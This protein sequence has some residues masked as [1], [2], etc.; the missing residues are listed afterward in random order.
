MKTSHLAAIV[1]AVL[2]VSA[3]PNVAAQDTRTVLVQKIA[4]A[5]GLTELVDQQLAQQHEATKE[6][7]AKLFEEAVTAG[8][9]Q[10]NPEEQAAFDKFVAR[11]G[12]IFSGKEFT[13][14]WVTHYG[15]E[16]SLQDLQAILSYYESPVGRKDVAATKSAMP[17]FSSWILQEGQTRVEPLLKAFIAE[18]QA[19][20]E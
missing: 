10:A 4:V 15:K 8:G 20:R 2:V 3:A 17:A 5:Q 14:A 19:A 9:G 7:A 6:Y 16:L 11:T 13:A 18:L 1:T 12:E